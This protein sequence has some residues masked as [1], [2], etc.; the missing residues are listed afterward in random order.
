LRKVRIFIRKVRKMLKQLLC[1][2]DVDYS[3]TE[4]PFQIALD[5]ENSILDP[6]PGQ[7]Q[8]F[9]YIVTGVGSD[10]PELKDLSHW[11]L[12]ICDLITEDDIIV[13]SITV[14]ID[15][16][17]QTVVF[18][19]NVELIDPDPTTGCSGLKF[20]FPV[21]K[22]GG[23]MKVCFEL[24][25]V[26]QVG[27]NPVCLKGGRTGTATGQS[28]CGPACNGSQNC[29]TFTYQTATVCAPVVVTPVA[30]PG[31]T[32]TICCGDPVITPGAQCPSTTRHCYFTVSQRV[33]IEVPITFGATA[34]VREPRI[35]CEEPSGEGCIDCN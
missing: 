30:T 11:V 29:Q 31:T 23:E 16:E 19:D 2:V 25:N 10:V 6:L 22:L 32:R 7:N 4:V 14:V 20:D 35:E 24:E 26:Y 15:D 9:C 28:I 1:N 18:G 3:Q 13:E 34:E 33:C 5:L 21:S 27:P 8:K 12:G 17:P